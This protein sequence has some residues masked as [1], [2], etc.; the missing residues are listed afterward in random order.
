MDRAWIGWAA[1]IFDGEGSIGLYHKDGK[2]P[3]YKLA[4]A[5][6]CVATLGQFITVV[7]AGRIESMYQGNHD[8]F[9]AA[10]TRKNEIVRVLHL[11]RPYLIYKAYEADAMLAYFNGEEGLVEASDRI[12]ELK[13]TWPK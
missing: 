12:K 11:L 6:K 4:V 9:K 3:A 7:G 8:V 10:I 1:G 2:R 5:S 13:R